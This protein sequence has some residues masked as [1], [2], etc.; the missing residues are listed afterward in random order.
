MY[1]ESWNIPHK[2]V[3]GAYFRLALKARDIAK[4]IMRKLLETGEKLIRSK[5]KQGNDLMQG[6]ICMSM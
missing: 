5:V 1:R 4:I 2:H 3:H 6:L